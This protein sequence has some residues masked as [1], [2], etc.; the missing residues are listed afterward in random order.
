MS[1]AGRGVVITRP[2]ELAEPFARLL[3]R[4][5]ARAIVF[6]A[7]EIQ[8][9]PAPATLARLAEYDVAVFVS[10]SAVRIALAAQPPWPPRLAAAVGAG[11][12]RELER[13]GAQAVIAPTVGADSEALL[14]LPE[15]QKLRGKRVLIVR[16]K[17]GR[18][19]L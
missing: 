2:R 6:P 14:A 5:G 3:E 11:T 19:L 16:G 1:L 7:I 12:R 15:M 18:E 17:G 10:P 8:P 4:R 13:A 9:L